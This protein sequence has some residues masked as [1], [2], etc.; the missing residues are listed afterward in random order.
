MSALA[1]NP[2][3]SLS[4]DPDALEFPVE[5]ESR[6]F[7]NVPEQT[8]VSPSPAAAQ[9]RAPVSQ[10][11]AITLSLL[12]RGFGGLIIVAAFVLFLFEGWRESDD[13]S[14]GLLLIGHTLA[15]TLAGLASGHWLH[16]N[17]GARLFIALAL[18]AVPVNVAFVGGLI[19]P[20][21]T[22]DASGSLS[23]AAS[24]WT[25]SQGRLA[26]GPALLL[27]VGSLLA[28]ALSVWLGLR[29]MARQSVAALSGLYL[30]AN[31]ALLIPTRADVV[32][33]LMLVGLTLTLGLFSLRLRQRD[34]TLAT[35]EGRFARAL[36]MLP[37]LILAGRSLWLYAP[38]ALFL[39]TLSLLGYLAL[40]FTLA[41]MA[42]A[43][44]WRGLIETLAV[45]MALFVTTLAS[46]ALLPAWPIAEGVHLP[47]AAG[48]FATMLLD[49]SQLSERR[50][51]GYQSTAALLLSLSLLIDLALFG[52]FAL[53]VVT[54]VGGLAALGFG[55]AIRARLLFAIG[56]MTALSAL[57]TLA[58]DALSHFSLGGW[59]ALVL[60]GIGIIIT[61]SALERHGERLKTGL[62]GWRAHFAQ[63]D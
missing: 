8:P 5:A 61:G 44:Q 52:G 15:L 27:S 3:Q 63:A 12:L 51:R 49:L 1:L 22:W 43:S 23:A 55:Y 19:Y 50:R 29:I 11:S 36:L 10:G 24:V 40:R 47:L 53:A 62:A 34:P 31:A 17:K 60:L 42:P 9:D 28:L 7:Q 14:R 59:S 41:A 13:L 18:A 45:I 46:G 26:M 48:I 33:S 16:E 54:L 38:D 21:L 4:L 30:L 6:S 58:T 2:N 25:Q 57:T 56:V 35:V 32:V 37:L 20:F 39:T